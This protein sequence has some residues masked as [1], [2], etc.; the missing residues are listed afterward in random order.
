[1]AK[2]LKG[3]Q[4]STRRWDWVIRGQRV[5]ISARSLG[6]FPET[7]EA[8]ESAARAYRQQA[9][10]RITLQS[11]Q[12]FAKLIDTWQPNPSPQVK[13]LLD[14]MKAEANT[15]WKELNPIIQQAFQVMLGDWAKASELVGAAK[16]VA[17]VAP[18]DEACKT[19]IAA[20]IAKLEDRVAGR[21]KKLSPGGFD[22]N[23]RCILTFQQ[24]FA[25]SRS[26]KDI[27]RQLCESYNKHVASLSYS[28]KKKKFLF[29]VFQQFVSYLADNEHITMPSNLRSKDFHFQDKQK[30]AQHWTAEQFQAVYKAGCD[31][32]KLLLLLAANCGFY[33]ADMAELHLFWEGGSTVTKARHKQPDNKPVTYHFWPETLELLNRKDLADWLPG[34]WSM[35]LVNSKVKRRTRWQNLTKKFPLSLKQLRHTS[36][37]FVKKSKFR[38]CELEFLGDIPNNPAATN[39]TNP[40][41]PPE[42][43]NHLH[44]CYFG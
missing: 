7:R 3:W 41:L 26:I 2:R 19:H 44:K 31:K 23:R 35:E 20:W 37:H 25:P 39:Y 17:A 6:I 8:S 24:W 1:M 40:D 34:I 4:S 12:Q 32:T 18:Q 16:A 15:D 5:T 10:A 43:F 30:I 9:T 28:P 36:S 33:P 22:N 42:L 13:P 29:N 11:G 21:G 27:N 14:C 38:G